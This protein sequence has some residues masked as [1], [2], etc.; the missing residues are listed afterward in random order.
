MVTKLWSSA[1]IQWDFCGI[2][3]ASGSTQAAGLPE[4]RGDL[5]VRIHRE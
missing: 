2:A 3:G 4:L 1:K 5:R